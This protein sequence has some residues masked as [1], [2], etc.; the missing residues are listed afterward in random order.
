[1]H[2]SSLPLDRQVASEQYKAGLL[3]KGLPG[4][5]AQQLPLGQLACQLLVVLLH[6]LPAPMCL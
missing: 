2:T 6:P 1:M 4:L 3:H 5:Q